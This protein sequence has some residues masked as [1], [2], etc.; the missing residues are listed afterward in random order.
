LLVG[1][2]LLLVAGL[3][4]LTWENHVSFAIETD[5]LRGLQQ[6]IQ[7]LQDPSGGPAT[8]ADKAPYVAE[9]HQFQ[10]GFAQA[11]H[12]V[13]IQGSPDVAAG[14]LTTLVGLVI[15]LL[16]GAGLVGLE[17]GTGTRRTMILARVGR[18]R[19]SLALLL[20]LGCL[21]LLLAVVGFLTVVLANALFAWVYHRPEGDVV[22]LFSLGSLWS[23]AASAIALWTWSLIGALGAVLTN[24]VL[25]GL[26]GAIAY[27]GAD[28]IAGQHVPGLSRVLLTPNAW[29]LAQWASRTPPNSS[30]LVPR[31][32]LESWGAF[33]PFPNVAAALIVFAFGGLAAAALSWIW[34][35][36]DILP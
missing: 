27:V 8:A 19:S 7:Q 10:A 23:L 3:T 17:L 34:K 6:T 29:I 16:L 36:E 1:I 15:G 18:G 32:W 28:F 24:S 5:T 25:G 4:F 22:Q 2:F 21:A 35:A 14:E 26:I 13:Q 31:I 12:E 30:L 9:L 20:A 11:R 33:R